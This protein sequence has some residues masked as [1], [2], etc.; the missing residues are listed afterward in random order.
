MRMIQ[1]PKALLL[2]TLF[3]RLASTVAEK[4]AERSKTAT[5]YSILQVIQNGMQMYWVN[6]GIYTSGSSQMC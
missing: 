1:K 2:N 3:L 4:V 6:Y 5:R